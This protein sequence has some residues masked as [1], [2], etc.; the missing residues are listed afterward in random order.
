[1]S[2]APP[3]PPPAWRKP[4]P[5]PDPVAV[6]ERLIVRLPRLEDDEALFEAV[7]GCREQLLPWLPW[8][9]A[10]H[11]T[12][13]ESRSFLEQMARERSA[14]ELQNL[15]LFILERRGGALVG[16]TGF[17]RLDPVHGCAEIGYW[18]RGDRRRRGYCREAV[19]GLITA[20]F[21]DFGLRRI[22]I[23]CA[24]PNLG[25]V[26]V[27]ERL[28]LRLESRERLERFVPGHGWVDSLAF[29]VLAQE[30]SPEAG[31]VTAPLARH[32][33]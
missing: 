22:R 29:G 4:D 8:A 28:G 2:A 1:M 32:E 6:T 27:I 25:S 15:V 21:R 14:A 31:R 16:G 3:P 10:E 17:H 24:A 7:S 30:W 19:A 20:A 11:Q 5:L 12:V 13:G 33:R 18:T 9:A 26:A 23:C